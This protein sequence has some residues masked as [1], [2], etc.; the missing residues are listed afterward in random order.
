MKKVLVT[1]GLGYIG[2]AVYKALVEKGHRVSILGTNSARY[3]TVPIIPADVEY[4][5]GDIMD[6]KSIEKALDKANPDALVHCAGL[7]GVAESESN[8]KNFWGLNVGG[9]VNVAKAWGNRGRLVFTSSA[10][11]YA[12]STDSKLSEYAKVDP[13]ST[14]GRTKLVAEGQ[15]GSNSVSLRCFNPAGIV[16]GVKKNELMS[17]NLFDVI[18]RTEGILKVMG[19]DFNTPDGSSVKDYIHIDDVAAAHVWAIENPDLNYRFYNIGTG[20]GTSVIKIMNLM[21]REY[22]V[23][24]RRTGDVASW[25]SDSSGAKA[26]GF[27][28]KKT[29][30][31]IIASELESNK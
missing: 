21:N 28:C 11:V 25:V 1:G 31:D 23:L 3:G 15:L 22:E 6:L 16:A 7:K 18:R 20:I 26:E 17:G 12:P 9:T 13:T 4:I 2:S 19:G 10:S 24:P 14:Y 8:P 29:I 5:Q 27:E 30:E